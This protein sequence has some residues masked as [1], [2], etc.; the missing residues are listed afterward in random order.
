MSSIK[1]EKA[2]HSNLKDSMGVAVTNSANGH[3][4]N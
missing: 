3:T 2:P 4:I 1:V